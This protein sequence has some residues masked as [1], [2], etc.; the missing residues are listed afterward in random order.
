ME[1][2]KRIEKLRLQMIKAAADK[3]LKDPRVI[4]VSDKLDRL[5]NEFYAK[6]T[7]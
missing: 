1:L 4:K 7:A 2:E 5:I 6:R 3:D